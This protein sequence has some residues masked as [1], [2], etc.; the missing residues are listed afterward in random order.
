MSEGARF[1]SEY[2]RHSA[3]SEVDHERA[4]SLLVDFFVERYFKLVAATRLQ[5]LFHR[6]REDYALTRGPTIDNDGSWWTLEQDYRSSINALAATIKH[7]KME[8]FDIVVAISQSSINSQFLRLFRSDESSRWIHVRNSFRVEVKTMS[9]QLLDSKPSQ[10]ARLTEDVADYSDDE[11]D[12]ETVGDEEFDPKPKSSPRRAIVTVHILEGTLHWVLDENKL[13]P[14]PWCVVRR[15]HE[16]YMT[17]LADLQ[18]ALLTVHHTRSEN[19]SLPLKLRFWSVR[20]LKSRTGR[21]TV[22]GLMSILLRPPRI[23]AENLTTA[24]H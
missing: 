23:L 18:Y 1:A 3:F 8:G 16:A 20:R 22:L 24:S 6:I 4:Y 17:F 14:S 7:T 10:G 11:D 9:V 19:V 13:D 15:L 5:Y 2:S 12:D 21:T